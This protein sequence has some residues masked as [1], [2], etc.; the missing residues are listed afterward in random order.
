MAKCAQRS[1]HQGVPIRLSPTPTARCVLL[2]VRGAEGLGASPGRASSYRGQP[3]QA[4]CSSSHH[5]PSP[6]ATHTQE[7][8]RLYTEWVLERSIAA[9]FTAFR[10]G[11][12]RVCS[13]PALGLFT[14]PELE[15]LVCGLPHLDFA[16][17]QAVARYEGGY[18]PDHPTVQA[19]WEVRSGGWWGRWGGLG[20]VHEVE[21]SGRAGG[22][23]SHLLHLVRPP[24]RC[25]TPLAWRKRCPS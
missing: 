12:L 7:F 17:L 11:F 19:F 16:A 1:W 14:P 10:R 25:C 8:V 5:Q 18:S 6:T 15:L 22:T 24:Y 21:R 23:V 13:G 2:V 4:R 9:Q 3:W 20:G